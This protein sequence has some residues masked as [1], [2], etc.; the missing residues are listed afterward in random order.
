MS[1]TKSNSMVKGPHANRS[2]I[3]SLENLCIWAIKMVLNMLFFFAF[4]YVAETQWNVSRDYISH[5]IA[6]FFI[7]IVSGIISFFLSY[8][9][10]KYLFGR[11][12]K[13]QVKSFGSML[14]D[15]R[16]MKKLWIY[17]FTIIIQTIFFILSVNFIIADELPLSDGLAFVIA[18]IILWIGAKVIG[19]FLFFIFYTW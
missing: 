13:R 3:W 10:I 17:L 16:R 9:I 15:K 8:L 11:F 12:L 19:R 1:V 5:F 4:L 2:R 18:W 6:I 14:K 7:Y